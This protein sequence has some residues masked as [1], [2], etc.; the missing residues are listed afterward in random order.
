MAQ[1]PFFEKKCLFVCLLAVPGLC[2]S[3]DLRALLQHAVFLVVAYELLVGA[4]GI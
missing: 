2:S 3:W 1:F 4:C